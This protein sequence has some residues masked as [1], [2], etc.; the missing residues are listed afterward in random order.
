[1]IIFGLHPV[2]EAIKAHAP[3]K[4]VLLARGGGTNDIFKLASEAGITI[5]QTSHEELKK[6][7]GS[8][9]HQGIAAKIKDYAYLT[10]EELINKTSTKQN[11]VF[12]VLD[13]IKDPQ[14][15]GAIIRSAVCFGMD[16]VILPK[17]RACGITPA[18]YKTSAGAVNSIPVAL[19]TNVARGLDLL[20]KNSFWVYGIEK[21]GER[22]IDELKVDTP[23]VIVLGGEESGI[24]ELIRKKCD[25]I[26][27]IPITG[28][29]SSLNVSVAAAIAM[30]QAAISSR[31][32]G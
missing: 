1:M 22:T 31:V 12:I 21:G 10:V 4:E 28:Q 15:L 26:F 6:L 24:R 3:V 32:Q 25:L 2:I 9:S 29:I 16:G 19:V 23:S 5:K 18:V 8:S 14:N 20:K 30:Y 7:T 13:S 17:D 27:N 11:P